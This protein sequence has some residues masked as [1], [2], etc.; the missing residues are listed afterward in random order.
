MDIDEMKE[1]GFSDEEIEEYLDLR[2]KL[3]SKVICKREV[4]AYFAKAKGIL[5]RKIHGEID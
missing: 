2:R 5:E 3:N 1:I 4:E